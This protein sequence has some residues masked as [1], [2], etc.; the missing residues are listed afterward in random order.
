MPYPLGGYSADEQAAIVAFLAKAYGLSANAIQDYATGN[1]ASATLF[2]KRND[3][4]DAILS[5][6]KDT[7]D[8]EISRAGV[9]ETVLSNRIN[10]IEV[11]AST[12]VAAISGANW[13][14]EQF[15][16]NVV[17]QSV[18][19]TGGKALIE[20]AVVDFAGYPSALSAGATPKNLLA[21]GNGNYSA[22][23]P[24]DPIPADAVVFATWD[25]SAL[26]VLPAMQKFGNIVEF[27][28]A[29]YF[30]DNLYIGDDNRDIV[31]VHSSVA[32]VDTR[33]RQTTFNPNGTIASIAEKDELNNVVKLTTFSYD[34][35]GNIATTT[36]TVGGKTIVETFTYAAD[37]T[38]SDMT[39]S[40]T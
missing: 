25:G 6:L 15:Q 3:Q 37:G 36:T 4:M 29:A 5:Y 39:K 22:E 2:N 7:L 34:A 32:E 11:G 31:Y 17:G 1:F 38:I 16:T 13:I 14:I 23:D 21:Y 33:N 12:N 20:G 24:N 30:R 9:A 8:D 18:S 26:T 28:A 27:L 35:A 10:N 19:I 40:V